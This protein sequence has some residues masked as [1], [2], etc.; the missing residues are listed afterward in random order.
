MNVEE[1]MIELQTKYAYQ[2]DLLQT[3]NE[4][5]TQQQQ[6]LARLKEDMKRMQVSLRGMMSSQLA[7]PD[8]EVPPPHY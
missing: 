3:L 2:E 5:V 7:R 8:E 4:V 1:G 6:E